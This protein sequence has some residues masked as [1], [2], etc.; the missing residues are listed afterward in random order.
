[1]YPPD[2]ADKIRPL[3]EASVGT[4][5]IVPLPMSAEEKAADARTTALLKASKIVPSLLGERWFS[6]H[7]QNRKIGWMRFQMTESEGMYSFESE[8]R[9]EQAEARGHERVSFCE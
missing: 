4:F 9:N 7:V 2:R 1:M 8:V 3:A 6:I 5:E